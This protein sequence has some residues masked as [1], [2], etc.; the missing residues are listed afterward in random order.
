VF[1]LE[2]KNGKK[3]GQNDSNLEWKKKEQKMTRPAHAFGFCFA[4]VFF[5]AEGG[6]RRRSA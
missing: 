2:E 4:F 1:V 6:I 5:F 3:L